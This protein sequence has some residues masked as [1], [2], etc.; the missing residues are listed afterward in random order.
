[1]VF[2]SKTKKKKSRKKDANSK[3]RKKSNYFNELLFSTGVN[4]DKSIIS[5]NAK[6]ALTS[7]IS[8]CNDRLAYNKIIY[9][10]YSHSSNKEMR[11]HITSILNGKLVLS[12]KD[13]HST[14][15]LLVY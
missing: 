5:E 10:Y 4:P 3:L 2:T 15:D 9:E 8:L 6:A 1:M 12:D 14:I 13:I 11:E 7:I